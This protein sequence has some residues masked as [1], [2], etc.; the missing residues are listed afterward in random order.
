MLKIGESVKKIGTT[1]GRPEATKW[2][3]QHNFPGIGN[4][5]KEGY[6]YV[7]KLVPL[8]PETGK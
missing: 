2:L 7:L 6:N 1:L 4:G 8:D 3:R 5:L